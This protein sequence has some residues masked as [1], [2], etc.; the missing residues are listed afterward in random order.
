MPNT[1]GQR[2]TTIAKCVDVDKAIREGE[3]Q[4]KACR[5]I[6]LA[7]G[8]YRKWKLEGPSKQPKPKKRISHKPRLLT[9]PVMD[10]PAAGRLLCFMGSPAE[11]ATLARELR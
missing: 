11:L 3:S 5:R 8:S 9:L 4:E 10:Q 2:P 6:G 7:N 1:K